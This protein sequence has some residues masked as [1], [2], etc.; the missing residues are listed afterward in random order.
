MSGSQ[1]QIRQEIGEIHATVRGLD[2]QMTDT[3]RAVERAVDG[4]Q[5]DVS[6]LKHEQR[7]AQHAVYGSLEV[8]R[9]E[10]ALSKQRLGQ[11]EAD[12]RALKDSVSALQEPVSQ[13]VSLRK[14]AIGF[15]ALFVSISA[16]LWAIFSPFW[17]LLAQKLF[18]T[19]GK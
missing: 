14:R 17:T 7:N 1:G 3:V 5:R 18:G 16:V 11:M 19:L 6:A 15:G 4:M 12:M 8:V 2:R 9:N 10:Q 13:W